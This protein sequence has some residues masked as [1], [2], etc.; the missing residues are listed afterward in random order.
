[1]EGNPFT[2]DR[3]AMWF[4]PPPHCISLFSH[5]ALGINI[6]GTEK[7]CWKV[8]K[9]HDHVQVQCWIQQIICLPEL[10]SEF[11]K[12]GAVTAES[13]FNWIFVDY[14]LLQNTATVWRNIE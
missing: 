1:M 9:I 13:V 7:D 5:M 8:G 11:L 14:V 4:L 12:K 2:V 6:P 3:K 10:G